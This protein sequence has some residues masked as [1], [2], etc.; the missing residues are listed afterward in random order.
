MATVLRGRARESRRCHGRTACAIDLLAITAS[1]MRLLDCN[2]SLW[3]AKWFDQH[4]DEDRMDE[5]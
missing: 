5:W 1:A 2:C 3:L 4:V